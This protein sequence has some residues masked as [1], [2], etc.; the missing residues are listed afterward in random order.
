MCYTGKC[1]YEKYDGECGLNSKHIPFDALCYPRYEIISKSER[2]EIMKFLNKNKKLKY[3]KMF[4]DLDTY[5]KICNLYGTTLD[6]H[7][8]QL[9][10]YQKQEDLVP[11]MMDISVMYEIYTRITKIIR[12]RR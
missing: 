12:Q 5:E 10:E 9:E 11:D 1:I 2:K 8:K 6:S 4:I 7:L 3:S